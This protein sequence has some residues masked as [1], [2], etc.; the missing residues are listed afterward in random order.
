[1][2]DEHYQSPSKGEVYW[3]L[4]KGK[5]ILRVNYLMGEEQRLNGIDGPITYH[6][7]WCYDCRKGSDIRPISEAEFQQYYEIMSEKREEAHQAYLAKT[8]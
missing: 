3:A 5:G 1:M 4:P 8:R 6:D 2:L 7:L